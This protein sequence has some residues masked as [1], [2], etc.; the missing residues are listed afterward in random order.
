MNSG[1]T[2]DRGGG[3]SDPA[4]GGGYDPEP[5]AAGGQI[6]GY[7]GGGGPANWAENKIDNAREAALRIGEI[8]NLTPSSYQTQIDIARIENVLY[9]VTQ[10]NIPRD[11]LTVLQEQT[12]RVEWN[13]CGT[14]RILKAL[15]YHCTLIDGYRLKLSK[16]PAPQW[17]SLQALDITDL[18][19][20]AEFVISRYVLEGVVPMIKELLCN[21][22]VH[23]GPKPHRDEALLPIMCNCENVVV[24]ALQDLCGRSSNSVLVAAALRRFLRLRN[25]M[26]GNIEPF[27][28]NE[29]YDD[30]DLHA[31]GNVSSL[32]ELA[33][34]TNTPRVVDVLMAHEPWIPG[35]VHPPDNLGGSHHRVID[36]G[37]RDAPDGEF[38]LLE[39]C[40]VLRVDT[41][42]FPVKHEG[43][44]A[45]IQAF[46]KTGRAALL[47]KVY[48]KWVKD[49]EHRGI[50]MGTVPVWESGIS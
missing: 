15:C 49:S 18:P 28:I 42:Q 43:M 47:D 32:L 12:Y 11:L 46:E 8:D 22:L 4:Y 36:P 17:L 2:Y 3:G 26:N 10:G 19:W 25:P 40:F 20:E 1:Y 45:K 37:C 6:E 41:I 21:H 44:K 29:R 38:F 33:I 5:S 7:H 27:A 50:K 30:Y 24:M 39:Q 23:A 35:A 48:Q 16:P 34:E 14:A 13:T 31:S 9:T